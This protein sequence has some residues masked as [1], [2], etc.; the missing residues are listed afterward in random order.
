[1]SNIKG[2]YHMFQ[3]RNFKMSLL[4]IF[5]IFPSLVL[6][7]DLEW[8]GLYQASHY[9][10]YEDI[11][12]G[13]YY[14]LDEEVIDIRTKYMV[15]MTPVI[16]VAD[17]IRFESTVSF[18]RL[19]L[20]EDNS[21][22][23]SN[24]Y[25][26]GTRYKGRPTAGTD[27]SLGA[28]L[29]RFYGVTDFEYFSVY[30]GRMPYNFGLGM[31][32]SDGLSYKALTYNVRDAL[33]VKFRMD[34]FYFKPAISFAGVNKV[35]LALEGG[36]KTDDYGVA[37]LIDDSIYG[38][39]YELSIG[40]RND[41]EN[42]PG[43][44][45]TTTLDQVYYP[46]TANLYGYYKVNEDISLAAEVGMYLEKW[47][48][49]SDP[50]SN[51][52]QYLY[53]GIVD[54]FWNTGYEGIFVNLMAGYATN[55]YDLNPNWTP[56]NALLDYRLYSNETDPNR[57]GEVASMA[58]TDGLAVTGIVGKSLNDRN[59]LSLLYAYMNKNMH[60][61][62]LIHTYKTNT[63]FYWDNFLGF[64]LVGRNGQMSFLGNGDTQFFR[65]IEGNFSLTDNVPIL[66][67]MTR[68]AY[69]F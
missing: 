40:K 35:D 52:N 6:G 51:R 29:M 4:G 42:Y 14:V 18:S 69:V 39:S 15:E 19:F 10:M 59:D 8:K 5:F 34:D 46:G 43:K 30:V 54:L 63:G 47:W 53:G 50:D 13:N 56:V 2:G 61:L 9:F 41:P 44:S 48:L 20:N 57:V 33:A 31:T 60:E 62:L 27:S 37:V 26:D 21:T 25:L 68:L 22:I 38:S 11:Q 17:G 7:A 28:E 55:G 16:R 64:V 65:D 32:Y 45:D 58:F 12:E 23:I 3:F 1:M 67:A 36:Y 49:P 66:Q 24:R